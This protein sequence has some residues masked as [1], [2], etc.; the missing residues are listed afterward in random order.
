MKILVCGGRD[1]ND[2][3]YLEEVLNG[4]LAISK[5]DI[6]IEGEAK[7]AD[8]LAR[9]WADKNN[10]SVDKY[11]A[12]WDK[13]GKSAGFKRNEQMLIEGKPDLVVAFPGGNGTRH[14]IKIAKKHGFPVLEP[15][16]GA[17]DGYC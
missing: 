1:F 8:T 12:D 17:L 13:N 15:K 10:I 3:A 5:V 4:I 16:K 6:I 2:V 9:N 7:G 14:M 11:P